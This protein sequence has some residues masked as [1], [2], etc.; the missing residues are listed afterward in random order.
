MARQKYDYD[1]IV[2]G[3]GGGGSVAAHIS[4]N[5]GK[6]V[7]VVENDTMG[8]E[9]PN[10][11]C[12]PTKALLHAAGIYDE[13]RHGQ[14]FGIRGA[15]LGYNYPSIKAWKDLAVHR[16]GTYQGKKMFEAEGITVISGEAHFISPH[17]I[18]VN[19]RHF[20]SE[21]FLIATGSHTFIPPIE[22]L[23][24]A[25]YVTAREV[26]DLTRPPKSM[27]VVGAGAIGCEFTE[28]FS[29]FGTKI[30]L[31]DITP[32]LLMKEDQEVGELARQIFEEKRGVAVL[33][34]TKVMRVAKEGL[35]KRVYY[36]QGRE[37]KSVKVD[38]ILIATGKL[39]NVDIGLENAGVDYTP[40]AVTVNEHMQTS[41]KHIYAAG[42][43]AGPYQFT[44]T[45]IY[46][47]RLAAHN[48]WH[49][50][51]VAADYRAIPRCIFINPE[52]ASVG[53]SEDECI[54][55]DMKFKKALA[56]ISIIGRANTTNTDDGFVKVI[57]E[58]DGTL[59]GASIVSPRAG[60][61]LHELTLAI[62]YGLTAQE[63]ANTIHA[64]PTWSEAVRIACA[65]IK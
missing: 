46:Q 47:S 64:F 43:V 60:E 61:M 14:Q 39:A 38:E 45:A 8:G 52:V 3:S 13:A 26:V 28:L 54:R 20:S 12:I 35:A 10:W 48:M 63:V 59:I 42:D 51:K 30:Y 21:H 49:K 11:G 7:A 29:T 15:T 62:Q 40:K 31:A 65:K 5:L 4:T 24:Q 17:E 58:N 9:C 36:Q 16:T 50:Q 34:N 57:T 22:G 23:E 55:R 18:T 6:R 53:M 25:G 19:R 32:R 27:F 33:M 2:L 44:H 1:L 56:P 41:A 37:M